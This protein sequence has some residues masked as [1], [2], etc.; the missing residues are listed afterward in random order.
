[1]KI[2]REII[3]K[4]LKEVPDQ[5][6]FRLSRYMFLIDVEFQRRYGRKLT[7]FFYRLYPEAFYIEGFPQFLESI[8]EIEKQVE[9]DEQGNPKRGYFRLVK[10]VTP[11]LPD[12]VRKVVDF[13]IGKYGQLNDM[14]LNRVVVNLP[15]YKRL[16]KKAGL[17]ADRF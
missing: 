8:D 16:L 13:V 11:Q 17:S 10:D 5:H 4:I 12:D 1:M 15:E 7:E 14:E 2:E 3:L 9:T 6:P